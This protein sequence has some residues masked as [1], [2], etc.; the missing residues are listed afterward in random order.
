[1]R[2]PRHPTARQT[3]TEASTQPRLDAGA[4]RHVGDPLPDWFRRSRSSW[5]PPYVTPK[6]TP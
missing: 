4:V 2:P 3:S 1:M 5:T 6:E